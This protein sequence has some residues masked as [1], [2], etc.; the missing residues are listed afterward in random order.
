MN[1]PRF[2][3]YSWVR[4]NPMK[5]SSCTPQ[6]LLYWASFLSLKY[7]NKCKKVLSADSISNAWAMRSTHYDKIRVIFRLMNIFHLATLS[8]VCNFCNAA[9]QVWST[10]PT[11]H[12]SCTAVPL[13]IRLTFVLVHVVPFCHECFWRPVAESVSSRPRS[14]RLDRRCCSSLRLCRAG[15]SPGPSRLRGTPLSSPL[16]V[17]R[18]LEVICRD[19]V[20]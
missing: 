20:C 1:I 8:S 12:A 16:K 4:S 3:S 19:R 15:T 11:Q 13:E 7:C 6:P 17:G 2:P 9:Y 14:R 18:H 5:S 10:I